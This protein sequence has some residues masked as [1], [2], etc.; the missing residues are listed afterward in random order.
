MEI[1]PVCKHLEGLDLSQKMLDEAEEK[2]IYDELIKQDILSYLA[3]ANLNFDYFIATDVFVYI[4]DLSDVFYLI[5]SR[6]KKSGKLAFSTE[7][8]DGDDY[9]LRK[10]GRYSHSKIYIES[11]CA[12][13]GYSL[14]HFETQP[15][16]KEKNQY[17]SGGL[18]LLDF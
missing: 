18:Y 12:T 3:S 4:G 1:K 16:R 5:K 8:C 14:R 13:F 17:I 15:L 10:S 11:L 6:N 2:S 7:H 9:L